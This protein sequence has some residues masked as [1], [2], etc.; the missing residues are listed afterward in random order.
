MR[1]NCPQTKHRMRDDFHVWCLSGEIT[2]GEICYEPNDLNIIDADFID[3][4]VCRECYGTNYDIHLSRSLDRFA[5]CGQ[6][7]LHKDGQV[8]GVKYDRIGVVLLNAVKEQQTQIE[9]QARQLEDQKLLIEE[10][11]KLVCAS[12]PNAAVCK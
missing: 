8:E 2:T 9:T 6:R 7:Q 11:K 3:F 4:D 5:I 12:N 1:N 10:L